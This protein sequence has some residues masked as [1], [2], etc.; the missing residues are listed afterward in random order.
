MCTTIKPT[1]LPYQELYDWDGAAEFVADYLNFIALDPPY[2]L[3]NIIAIY[4]KMVTYNN[5]IEKIYF[6]C[7]KWKSM[8]SNLV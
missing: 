2:E 1:Q 3:V 6:I 7:M 8:R 5:M 4:S